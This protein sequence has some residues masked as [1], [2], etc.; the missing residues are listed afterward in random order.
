MKT[1]APK[2]LS[3][4]SGYLRTLG[5]LHRR[6]IGRRHDDYGAFQPVR[7]ESPVDELADFTTPLADQ[8]YYGDVRLRPAR[9]H[10]HESRLTRANGRDHSD[11]LT[12][13]DRQ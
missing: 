3:D 9:Q 6:A 2:T 7:A 8:G 12:S 10:A 1:L 4:C 11:A 5:T 13:A